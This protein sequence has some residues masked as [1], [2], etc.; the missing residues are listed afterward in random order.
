MV[1]KATVKI[2]VVFSM[3]S[4]RKNFNPIKD[5]FLREYLLAH[6]NYLFHNCLIQN[7][8]LLCS[9]LILHL[10]DICVIGHSDLVLMHCLCCDLAYTYI[11]IALDGGIQEMKVAFGDPMAA[12][13]VFV[14]SDASFKELFI[15][16]QK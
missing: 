8:F 2:P 9:K 15:L 7:V 5:S 13:I 12:V 14:I 16:C 4:D 6:F 1:D 3:I 10:L 11:L